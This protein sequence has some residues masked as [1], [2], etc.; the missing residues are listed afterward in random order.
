MIRRASV[1]VKVSGSGITVAAFIV[2]F[3]AMASCAAI[4]SGPTSPDRLYATGFNGSYMPPGDG[5]SISPG[6]FLGKASLYVINPA[7]G[8]LISSA[9][10]NEAGLFPGHQ[11][12]RH[13]ALLD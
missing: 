4:A 1:Y 6:D 12:I 9:P 5:G 3:L 2:L 10:M 8:S 11:P 7:D 13:T